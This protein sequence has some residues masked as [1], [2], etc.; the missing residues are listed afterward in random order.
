MVH[1]HILF[2]TQYESKKDPA[3]DTVLVNGV[4]HSLDLVAL[5]C[6]HKLKSKCPGKDSWSIYSR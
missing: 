1:V 3:K 2:C 4:K 5:V 6:Y